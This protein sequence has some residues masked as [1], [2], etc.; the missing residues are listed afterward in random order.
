MLTE[1]RRFSRSWVAYLLLFIL[2]ALFVLFLGNGQSLLDTLQVQGSNFVAKGRGYQITAPQL[3]RELELTLRAQRN[4]GQNISQADAVEAG[5]HRQLLEGMIAR[6]AFHAY[7]D[8][9]G[10]S[11]SNAQVASRIREIP[12]VLN[13]VSGSFDADAY[14]RFLGELRYTQTEFEQDIRGDLTSDMLMEALI[15][16]L[17]APSSYGAMVLTY[18][19]ET[20]V[21][22]AAEAPALLVG[23]I[24]APTQEQLQT[25]YQESQQQLRVPEYRAVTLVYARPQ[26]FV[27]RVTIPEDR[28]EQEL[29]AR[30]AA[31][32]QPEKRTYVRISAQSEQQAN[33]AAA[34]LARGE[35]PAAIATALGVQALRAENQA[36]N[37]V[38][39]A[40]VA[41]AVFATA[42]RSAARVIRAQLTPWAVVRVDSVTAAVEPDLTSVR[43]E[44]RQAIA[45]DEAG[46]LL[47]DA[48]TAFEDA[49]GSGTAVAEAAR[50]A[51][52]TV[53]TAPAVD[54]HGHDQQDQALAAFAEQPGLLQAVFETPEG[55]SS[56][57]MPVGDADVV[58]SVDRVTP[59]T[60]RPFDT[61]RE[62]LATVWTGRERARRMRELGE[63]LVRAVREGQSF[64][65]AARAQRFRMVVNG[66]EVDR[67]AASQ[68]PARG[69]PAQIFAASEGAV[70]SE[71]RADGGAVLA[72]V[73][74]RINRVNAAERP[75]E[76]EAA[77]QQIQ[78][79]L[80]QSFGQTVQAEAVAQS[81]TQRNER[82]LNQLY[83]SDAAQAEQ[84]GQ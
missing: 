67:R 3:A 77:R 53:V 35:D 32:T 7:A 62:Q 21:I 43:A 39:D 9:I 68:I 34:R 73:V 28:F 26:D 75:Q 8:R 36:R 12:A 11:A 27:S 33:D 29:A 16:G 78:Q 41:E 17:R 72:V 20:R 46:Q 54:E 51:G 70:L 15:A 56:E 71:V 30:R 22:S 19:G 45:L 47:N 80:Q 4:Q 74:E 38:P 64:A 55:E 84:E 83:P 14:Q 69:L 42:P 52:L 40:R 65:A 61:V 25:L 63:N 10:V 76:V 6:R 37:E 1:M 66:Q 57:F 59:S 60:V 2:A 79:S 48:V 49:R 24:P 23:A 18:D 81:R 5:I 82:L 13:P 31:L 50:Q 58:V 44:L